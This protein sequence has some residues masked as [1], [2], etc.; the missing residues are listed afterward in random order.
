MGQS[1]KRS[2]RRRLPRP[3]LISP[4][5]SM[6]SVS[7]RPWRADRRT[8]VHFFIVSIP[9]R[10]IHSTHT[11]AR[12]LCAWNDGKASGGASRRIRTR[13]SS[14]MTSARILARLTISSRRT[15]KSQN[16]SRP[17]CAGS[18]LRRPIDRHCYGIRDYRTSGVTPTRGPRRA[19][20]RCAVTF[21][22]EMEI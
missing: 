20:R 10:R 22:N 16:R 5:R 2:R 3:T 4:I 13:L 1:G 9:A 15:R 19:S 11:A 21:S 12:L 18:G 14:Y 17:S 7:C 8:P 6:A